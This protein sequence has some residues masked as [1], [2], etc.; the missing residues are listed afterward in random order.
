MWT[1]FDVAITLEEEAQAEAEKAAAEEAA[2]EAEEAYLALL[3][4]QQAQAEAA[5]A[6]AESD[7]PAESV[8][9]AET[10][11]PSETPAPTEAVTETPAPTEAPSE[12]PAPVEVPSE[13]PAPTEVVAETPAPTEAPTETQTVVSESDVNA[14][15]RN[16]IVAFALQFNGCPYVHGGRSLSQGTDCS[17]FTNMIYQNFGYD[18]DWTPAGQAELGTRIDYH[19]VQPGDLLFYSNSQK[20]LGHVALYIGN[21]QIIHAA[22]E[23]YGICIWDMNYREPL[24]AVRIIN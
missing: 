9:T 7:L 24:F 14:A 20:Y 17:G 6:P 5:T 2:R 19:D 1:E 3:A 10:E 18:L 11:P 13:T 8:V 15:L 16:A 22:N 12:A 21:G 23:Q 4:Q